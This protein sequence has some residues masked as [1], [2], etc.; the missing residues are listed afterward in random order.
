MGLTA[1]HRLGQQEDRG[2]RTR[3]TQMAESAVHQSLHS[4]GEVVFLEEFAA[5]DLAVEESIET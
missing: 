1:A 2:S 3:P 5:M 4:L